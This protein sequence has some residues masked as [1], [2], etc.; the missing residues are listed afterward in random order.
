MFYRKIIKT[1]GNLDKAI[2]F[3][4][5]MTL[6]QKTKYLHNYLIVKIIDLSNKIVY[7][8]TMTAVSALHHQQVIQKLR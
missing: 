4:V 3:C 6:Y 7:S 2:K 1:A 8:K 5:R